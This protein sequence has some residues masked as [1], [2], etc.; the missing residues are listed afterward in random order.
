MTDS[1]K[2]T[3][4]PFGEISHLTQ[5]GSNFPTPWEARTY[6]PEG[7]DPYTTISGEHEVWDADGC[8]IAEVDS[9]QFADLIAAAPDLLGACEKLLKAI[10]PNTSPADRGD[11]EEE[12]QAAIVKAK[13]GDHA[14]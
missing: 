12:A 13:G 6:L 10:H 1:E 5:S 9:R 8:I 11:A 14:G 3:P 7:E 4:G 2:H